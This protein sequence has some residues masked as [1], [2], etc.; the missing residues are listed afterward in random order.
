MRLWLDDIR[1]PPDASWHWVKTSAEAL[2]ALTSDVTE[3]S[4]DHD[5]G[6]DDTAIRVANAIERKAREGL[7]NRIVWHVHSA[8]PVGAARLRAAMQGA[9]RQWALWEL[10]RSGQHMGEYW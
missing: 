3:L 8:N 7:L 10:T 4:L 1:M 2:A 6:G 5:L 9:E